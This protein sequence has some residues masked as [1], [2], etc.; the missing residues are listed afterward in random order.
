MK[1]ETVF[2]SFTC[3]TV[4]ALALLTHNRS[5][6][7]VLLAVVALAF[8]AP[9]LMTL[10]AQTPDPL[11]A[12]ALQMAAPPEIIVRAMNTPNPVI[13]FLPMVH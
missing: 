4:I 5:M 13:S 6:T 9:M 10:Q 7:K 8:A 2:T 12:R 1:H 3:F 11:M